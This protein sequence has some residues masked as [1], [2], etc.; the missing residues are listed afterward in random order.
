MHSYVV[1]GPDHLKGISGVF[2][3]IFS[4]GVF[5]RRLLIFVCG[6]VMPPCLSVQGDAFASHCQVPLGKGNVFSSYL[7]YPQ[8]Y[9]ATEKHARYFLAHARGFV[10]PSWLPPRLGGAP[11]SN[12]FLHHARRS[13]SAYNS[14]LGPSAVLCRAPEPSVCN[15]KYELQ[16]CLQ[17]RFAQ[18]L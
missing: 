9:T 18:S 8:G 2:K 16:T 6:H 12:L 7:P 15:C 10:T 13:V 17:V 11:T 14:R 4:N 1:Q 5:L 3:A